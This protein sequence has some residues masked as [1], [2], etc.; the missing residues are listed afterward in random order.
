MCLTQPTIGPNTIR[1]PEGIATLGIGSQ[2]THLHPKPPS[3]SAEATKPQCP[4]CHHDKHLS[5]L[6]EF[7]LADG[8][9]PCEVEE[10]AAPVPPKC[11]C[12][13]HKVDYLRDTPCT[14]CEH[15][16]SVVAPSAPQQEKCQHCISSI[17]RVRLTDG[18]FAHAFFEGSKAWCEPCS[19]GE[20]RILADL[21]CPVHQRLDQIG[22][23]Q[24]FD[25][26]IACIRN[27]RDEL[28][29]VERVVAPTPGARSFFIRELKRQPIGPMDEGYIRFADKFAASRLVEKDSKI[30]Q[31]T[32][33]V[34][35]YSKDLLEKQAEISRLT[36]EL[37]GIGE[38]LMIV[39]DGECWEVG[40]ENKPDG[41][42]TLVEACQA[43]YKDAD[44]V[45][46]AKEELEAVNASLKQA[47]E[48]MLQHCDLEPEGESRF[49]LDVIHARN[50]L[51]SLAKGED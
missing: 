1:T 30:G 6:C 13:C 12:F 42:P 50:L 23:L 16:E 19:N 11:P 5:G 45:Q 3:V 44:A 35:V 9:C 36:A 43:L 26:C 10:V 47:L 32:G 39:W 8:E 37:K 28:K 46:K 17:K 21:L 7:G 24:P 27:E 40:F 41:F 33:L 25:N 29:V 20:A 49:E 2:S 4:T 31:L 22:K 48:R 51:A 15:P 34:A 18:T 14:Q 38:A